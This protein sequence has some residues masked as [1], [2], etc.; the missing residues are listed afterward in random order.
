M[1]RM[2][3]VRMMDRISKK[4]VQFY[5]ASFVVIILCI[6]GVTLYFWKL[7][8]I[9]GSRTKELHQASFI[10][11]SYENDGRFKELKD[12]VRAQ[13]PKLA[14]KKTEDIEG[15]LEK[16]HAQVEL[17]EFEEL[18]GDIQ[19]LKTSAA[20]LISF[21]KVSK[22]ISV[23][24]TKMNR[25]YEYVKD[26][27]WRTLTR[28][29][30]RVFS[31]TNGHIN[32]DKLGVLVKNLWRDFESMQKITENSVLERK[33]K[34]EIISRIS[35]LKV[36]IKMLKKY[37]DE[38]NFY[39]KLHQDTQNLM[40][41]WLDKVA[42]E[43]T[44]QKL[45]TEKIGRYYVLGLLGILFLTLCAFVFSF[46]INKIFV[47]K[48]QKEIENE[49]EAYVGEVLLEGKALDETYSK[50]F[51]KFS[52]KM[53]AYFHKRMSFG[54][55]FQDALPLS[56]VLLD[57]NLKVI[58]ANKHFC[59]D[60]DVSEEEIN[61]DYMS[62]DFL[63]KLTNI[64]DD[65][66]VLEALKNHVAGIYQVQVK[67]NDEAS[68]RPYE[69]F[70]SP[71]K[72]QGETRIML[73]F[74]DL[75]NIEQTIQDQ[76][77]SLVTPVRRSL[78]RLV[79]G[80]EI[81]N[82]DL[83][84]EFK[85]ADIEDVYQSFVDLD[86]HFRGRRENFLDEIESLN[87]RLENFKSLSEML[88]SQM[89]EA[90]GNT[91]KSFDALKQFKNAVISLSTYSKELERKGRQSIEIL[92]VSMG[93]IRSSVSKV[94][95]LKNVSYELSSALPRFQATKDELRQTKSLMYESKAKLAHEIS[96]LTLL[97]KKYQ[98]VG[99]LEKLNRV[100]D[101]ANNSL[102]YFNEHADEL[103]KKVASLELILSKAQMVSDNG[104]HQLEK[105][106]TQGERQQLELCENEVKSLS[107]QLDQTQEKIQ[108][109]EEDVVENLQHIF[110]S[111]KENLL[112]TSRNR[113][114]S[115]E[116]SV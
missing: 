61:K 11:N 50:D 29:S 80:E 17:P 19:K 58:W 45:K 82:E 36:E 20:N 56:S 48:G 57:K 34:A 71:T 39:Y 106:H 55:I 21:S 97:I 31:Q 2:D 60:W 12:L 84:R 4:L 28:L 81:E 40:R 59:E 116:A 8:F 32:Q 99:S 41:A 49:F 18:K 25:F 9:D 16:I 69:M 10:M 64:G 114:Q 90:L 5:Q 62:W 93:S 92:N 3:G 112:L 54:S 38:R 74:Y 37:V 95:T 94:E 83:M 77:K 68:V 7:G 105:V 109:T 63:S 87:E 1:W 66:P 98:D 113:S 72:Y 107:R 91:K 102:N 52:S 51:Q 42:P 101:K 13:N 35:N 30:D 70:V 14:I 103:D 100:I 53:S 111:T 79:E 85:I 26:N 65:D 24:N 15:E 43:L 46:L 44:L 89:Q 104:Q 6:L 96:Q 27:N 67:A 115:P 23:F 22:V 88:N 76:A 47:A 110:H 108:M 86:Q 73:F 75:T 78:S 33:D